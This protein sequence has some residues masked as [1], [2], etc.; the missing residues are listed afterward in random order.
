[1]PRFYTL[2]PPQLPYP[3]ILTNA[4]NPE[5]GLR[6]ITRYRAIVEAVII[7]A[8]V[9]MFRDPGLRDY[10]GGGRA[11]V[12]RVAQLWRRVTRVLPDAEVYA[13]VPDY[14]DDYHPQ[15][16]WESPGRTN[17]ERTLDNID[18][19]LSVHD[20]VDWLLPV[21][22]HYEN[23]GSVMIALEELEA[24]GAL[25]WAKRH[26]KYVAIA[27]LCVSRNCRTIEAT[28]ATARWWL[29]TRGYGDIR[30]HVFG[31][32]AR[33]VRRIANA[34][35]SWDSTAWTKPR[36]SGGSSAWNSDERAY[37]F[38]TFIARYTDL[39]ELPEHPKSMRNRIAGARVKRP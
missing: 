24:V 33:C 17:I 5:P 35:H 2:P 9:E 32:S 28:V 34:I 31:P 30:I 4:A 20:D 1:M 11:W 21:Q 15:S 6:Y 18:Y 27:N 23:P 16:L 3:F 19:A 10:P 13:T 14:P 26:T 25:R 37:L 22:G 29:N 12:D 36:T 38:I 39:I 8:G 7:D